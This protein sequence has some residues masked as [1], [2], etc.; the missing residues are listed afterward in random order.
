M[1]P[2]LSFVIPFLDEEQ[3]LAELF[4]RIAKA[5]APL[6]AEGETWELVFVDDGSRD[7]S[8]AVVEE[9]V[10][11]HPEVRLVELQ[12]NFG[13]SAALSANS[14]SRQRSR[15]TRASPLAT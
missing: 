12:G 11:K 2:K 10:E 13:K 6:L 15:I 4:D 1:R 3:T 5:V 7:E 9:L 8:V 14:P